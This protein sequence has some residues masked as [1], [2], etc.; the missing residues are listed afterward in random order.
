MPGKL[1]E[2]NLTGKCGSCKHFKP[3][4]G[5]ASGYCLMNKYDPAVVACDPENPYWLV[6]RS[7]I[8]CRDYEH[9]EETMLKI[10]DKV[11]MN[12]KY[13]VSEENREKVWT[14]RTEPWMVSGQL[15]VKL[16]G[17]AGGYAVDGLDLVEAVCPD[18]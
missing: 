9:K 5:T 3:K 17:K 18:R 2:I 7:R 6:T 8:R 14:V 1:K 15:V 10:G 13:Y 11:K 4:V 12:G 16:E